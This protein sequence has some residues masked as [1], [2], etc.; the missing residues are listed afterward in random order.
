M[1]VQVDAI[2]V[3]GRA[4]RRTTRGSASCD[5][6]SLLLIRGN[7]RAEQLTREFPNVAVELF[8]DDV[9]HGDS[10]WTMPGILQANFGCSGLVPDPCGHRRIAGNEPHGV[11][12]AFWPVIRFQTF[13]SRRQATIAGRPA[14]SAAERADDWVSRARKGINKSRRDLPSEF[15]VCLEWPCHCSPRRHR[16]QQQIAHARTGFGG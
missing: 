6:A 3:G 14:N 1:R 13:K 7:D 5:P 2:W 8:T 4:C 10:D 16:K 15:G 12:A 9:V 11:F